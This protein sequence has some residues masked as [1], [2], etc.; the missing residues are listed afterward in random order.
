[1]REKQTDICDIDYD[2]SSY[3]HKISP[4]YIHKI[5]IMKEQIIVSRIFRIITIILIGIGIGTFIFSYLSNSLL[6][7]ANY[8]IVNY[9]FLSLALGGAFFIVIQNISQSGWSSAFRRI[10]EAMMSYIPFAA[11]FFI[12]IYFGVNDL[13]HWSHKGAVNGI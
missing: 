2:H 12:I 4:I 5:F 13:Y 7:W 1:M 9:Y 11:V 8:L 10:P 6:T 3:W